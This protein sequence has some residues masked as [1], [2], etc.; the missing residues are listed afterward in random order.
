M[1]GR[2]KWDWR[3]L[4]RRKQAGSGR[5]YFAV[6]GKGTNPNVCIYEYPSLKLYRVLRSARRRRPAGRAC[7][8]NRNRTHARV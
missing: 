7:G 6:G 5:R 1:W 4:D 8:R 3:K 2:L